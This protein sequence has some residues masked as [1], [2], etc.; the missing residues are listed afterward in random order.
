MRSA[1][2]LLVVMLLG[3]C[4][5]TLPS[6]T[7]GPLSQPLEARRYQVEIP[8]HDGLT[9]A[10]TVYQPALASGDTA[11]VIIATH[12]FGG[13]RA[14]RPFSIYGKTMLTGE[15]AIAA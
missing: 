15:A 5:T 4:A 10:A 14:K 9:L 3:G 7:P 6:A 2:A 12:G 13:F 1:L 11:P 8:T